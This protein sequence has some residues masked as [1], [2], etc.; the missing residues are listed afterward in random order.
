MEQVLCGLK[1]GTCV[2]Y[3]DDIIVPGKSLDDAVINLKLVL[4]RLR[5]AGLRLSPSKCQLLRNKVKCLGHI[6][7]TEGVFADPEKTEAV[8]EW[9]EPGNVSHVRSFLGL[10]SYYRRF[11]KD[12]AIAHPLHQLVE[13]KKVFEWTTE[14]Q[15]AFD[16]LKQKLVNSPILG[17]PLED[18]PFI[19]D[20]DASDCSTG[21]VLSQ[22]V[23]GQ[24]RVVAYHSKTL[25]KSERNYCVTRRELLS[26][27]RAVKQFHVYLLG[28]RFTLRTDH[29]SLQWLVNFR[30][31][32]GQM[33]RWLQQLQ[34]YDFEIQHRPGKIHG[35]ADALSRRPCV[36]TFCKHCER[37]EKKCSAVKGE[38][39]KVNIVC[40]AFVL[41]DMDLMQ[42]QDED[43]DIQPI[44]E[45][46]SHSMERPPLE[47]FSPCSRI[48]RCLWGQWQS[49]IIEN[50]LLCRKRD[51]MF[52]QGRRLQIILPA[53]CRKDVMDQLHNSRCGGHFGAPRTFER[54]RQRFYWPGYHRYVVE[55]CRRCDPCCR[56]KGPGLRRNAPLKIRNEGEPFR[57]IAVDI[58]GPLPLSDRGNKYVAVVSD[59][60]T[61]WCEAFPLPNQ[62]ATTVADALV[63]QWVARYGVP[64][65]LH[66]DQGRNFESQVFQQTCML[67]GIHKTRTS[68]LHPQSDGMVERFNRTLEN[69]LT[70]FVQEHQRDW[71]IQIPLIMLAY[72]SSIH[73]AT[74]YTPSYLLFG[75]ETRLPIDLISGGVPE[76]KENSTIYA[77]NL[78]ERLTT[79]HEFARSNLR[80]AAASMKARYDGNVR[81][82]R[83]AIGDKVWL[84]APV[85]KRGLSPKLQSSWT[86]PFMVEK[87]FND[88]LCQIK[89]R[90]KSRVVHR[91][92]VALSRGLQGEEN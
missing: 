89:V 9:P 6:I 74:K 70:V 33:C 14:C 71:D 16:K 8:R 60:F 81:V 21:A 22:I 13:K 32:E 59:Y 86:G 79:A 91:N 2:V 84:F 40:K 92:R 75:R 34:G 17:L 52:N 29:S 65:E 82:D 50:G 19:L 55:W 90:Q 44:K 76:R 38:V 5:E 39:K 63:E 83:L 73:D 58:L 27:V 85:K 47:S 1:P 68:P 10:C 78:Q 67:L 31:P 69:S 80:L 7:N 62:E 48:L 42:R 37:T 88:Q 66:S 24:E 61:K 56:R 45:R 54:V 35:N 30:E 3:L 87:I 46:M 28:R 15:C 20:T 4:A 36:N 77:S 72:R 53:A 18:I 23:D 26:V 43:L 25:N 49:L 51:M 11:V 12:F 64:S 41:P 57:R